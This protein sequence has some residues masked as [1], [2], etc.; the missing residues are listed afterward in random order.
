MV[1]RRADVF[2]VGLDLWE[3]LTRRRL[4]DG[5]PGDTIRRLMAGNL[6]RVT[7]LVPDLPMELDNIVAKALAPDP[8]ERFQTAND[9][10]RALEVYLRTSSDWVQAE[11]IS[12]G[13]HA[14]FGQ[15]RAALQLQI[16][17]HLARM[18]SFDGQPGGTH[19]MITRGSSAAAFAAPLPKLDV[20]SG[21]S[22]SQSGSR[23]QVFLAGQSSS[24]RRY[25]AGVGAALGVVALAGVSSARFFYGAAPPDRG[26][27]LRAVRDAGGGARCPRGGHARHYQ[28]AAR[29][30][31]NWGWESHGDDSPQAGP[32]L[33]NADR[34]CV[35]SRVCLGGNP[36]P[37]VKSSPPRPDV[38]LPEPSTPVA[39][40]KPRIVD[41]GARPRVVTD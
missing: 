30:D 7:T 9:M 27:F 38:V 2:V 6:P 21:P 18:D 24:R 13:M 8:D 39:P 34:G 16:K 40:P 1:D 22:G 3:L 29:S 32:C 41:D 19:A 10:R 4:F 28:R 25:L 15:R 12:A 11:S 17:E 35:A 5:D 36:K 23:L 26:A 14:L 20:V 31:R 33:R 37:P